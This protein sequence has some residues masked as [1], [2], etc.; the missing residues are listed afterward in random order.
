MNFDFGNLAETEPRVN[1]LIFGMIG[2]CDSFDAVCSFGVDGFVE[3]DGSNRPAGRRACEA[4]EYCCVTS[5]TTSS[6]FGL[7]VGR[8]RLFGSGVVVEAVFGVAVVDAVAV[9]VD[10]GA[11]VLV[12][13]RRVR[14]VVV[15][16]L[17]TVGGA[18]AA[19]V[20]WMRLK[21]SSSVSVVPLL[22]LPVVLCTVGIS[23]STSLEERLFKSPVSL[24]RKYGV[25]LATSGGFIDRSAPLVDVGPDW[26]RSFFRRWAP[27]TCCPGTRAF[28]A[29]AAPVVV[30][31]ARPG[32]RSALLGGRCSLELT[33]VS[34]RRAVAA[35][36]ADV[37]V[38]DAVA[39]D[40]VLLSRCCRLAG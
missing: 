40:G 3:V 11:N 31:A 21:S 29:T 5:E 28:S 37:V 22:D 39:E 23:V 24:N 1:G 18:A 17:D 25:V 20:V 26:R 7:T 38:A 8:R 2:A 13:V 12:T 10:R 34:V 27:W 9:V 16:V 19:V 15:R 33:D 14:S 35:D 30:F 4:V 36:D 32:I 6:W